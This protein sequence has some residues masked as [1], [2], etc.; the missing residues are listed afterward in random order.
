MEAIPPIAGLLA[1]LFLIIICW[2]AIVD[3]L[4][5]VLELLAILAGGVAAMLIVA[6]LH[7]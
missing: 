2:P 7:H 4:V 3:I 6:A 5:D 1:L